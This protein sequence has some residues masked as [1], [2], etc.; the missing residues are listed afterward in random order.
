MVAH[1]NIK[2]DIDN[3]W[4]EFY[5]GGVTNPLTVIEQ[6]TY[7][8]FARMLDM[9]ETRNE[10]KSKRLNQEYNGIFESQDDP[11]RWGN[12]KEKPADKLMLIVRD[13]V[14]PMMRYL[15]KDSASLGKYM[16]N[17]TLMVQREKTLVAAVD[18]IDKLP[19]IRGDSKGDLYEYMLSKL[20]TAG[21]S[22]QFRTPRHI[23]QLMIKMLDPKPEDKICDPA[24][25]T[26]GFLTETLKYINEKY[27]SDEG[28][29][30]DDDGTV[31]FT[32]DLLDPLLSNH[33]Q[34]EFITG[35]DFDASMLGIS[36][37]NLMVNGIDNPKVYYQDTLST[38]FQERYPNESKQ[39][40]DIILANPPFKGVIDE[41]S[42]DP[43]LSGKVKTR[44][45]EL[46]FPALMLRM[47]KTG[48]KCA[49]ILP[50]GV[51]FGS[52]NAH[53]ALRKIL[54]EENQLEG[55]VSMP[56]GVFRPYAGVSTAILIF[57]K[58]GKTD[59]IWFYDMEDDGYSLDDK[60]NQL[61]EETFAG[62]LPKCLEAWKE[63]D[64]QKESDRSKKSFFVPLEEI[65]EN[66][67]DLTINR[68]KEIVYVEE[69]YKSPQIIIKDLQT[70][71]NQINYELENIENFFK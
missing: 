32:A 62:D 9:R 28:R 69:K 3:L 5:S 68:Y 59:N 31:H 13:K 47:L 23:I 19:L 70:L 16:E 42:V 8:M 46:L 51:L 25:G 18:I 4:M 34:N 2:S 26:A 54:I 35:F 53:I 30:K 10:K 45:T 15:S 56:S 58:G 14:F 39:Y 71:N 48:G 44:K 24:C 22:G 55:V 37:M 65:I 57:T 41:S 12:F 52:S 27:T 6:I 50:E 66:K 17:A 21:I 1:N 20:N 64:E 60:R 49:V 29:L 36:A 40:F 63:K 61:Y 11:R 33:I 67:Y 7:L 38:S 43:T